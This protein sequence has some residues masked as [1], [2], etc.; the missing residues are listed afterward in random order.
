[1]AKDAP[2]DDKERVLATVSRLVM[3][4]DGDT[5]YRDVY[6]NRAGDLLAPIVT[7]ASWVASL[8]GRDQLARLLAQA[9]AA[10]AQ[11]DWANVHETG[12]RAASLQRSLDA[13]KAVHAVAESVYGAPPVVLDPFSPGLTSK[14]WG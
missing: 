3:A 4:A 12:A 9:R 7:E 1:M 11:Q 6:L 2:E 10:V 5:L 13:D 14:R 8:G